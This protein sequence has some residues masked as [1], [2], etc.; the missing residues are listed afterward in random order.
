[1]HFRTGLLRRPVPGIIDGPP[2]ILRCSSSNINGPVFDGHILRPP[3]RQ[4]ATILKFAAPLPGDTRVR[5]SGLLVADKTHFIRCRVAG[6]TPSVRNRMQLINSHLH[7][8]QYLI[9]A[10]SA[11]SPKAHAFAVCS[12]IPLTERAPGWPEYNGFR[13]KSR[14]SPR[15]SAK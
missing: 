10:L 11:H 14:R 12:G 1:M 6:I 9:L 4:S 5:R 15:S 7:C 3:D 8:S 13:P 2:T